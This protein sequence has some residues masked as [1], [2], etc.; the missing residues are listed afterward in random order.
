M[1]QNIKDF[2]SEFQAISF[3]KRCALDRREIEI[4]GGRA[5]EKVVPLVTYCAERIRS[6]SGSVEELIDV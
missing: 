4:V 2:S 6:E 1:V 3:P 5:G